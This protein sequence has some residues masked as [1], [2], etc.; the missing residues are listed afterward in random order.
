MHEKTVNG[1]IFGNMQFLF[2]HKF[3]HIPRYRSR[4]VHECDTGVV[5]APFTPMLNSQRANQNIDVIIE[6]WSIY[7]VH[8]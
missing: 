5:G 6:I 1:I 3:A 7:Y 2:N 8:G 4:Q